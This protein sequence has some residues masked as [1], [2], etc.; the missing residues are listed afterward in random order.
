M[1][2]ASELRAMTFGVDEGVGTITLNRPDALNALNLELKAELAATIAEIRARP[3][4]RAVVVTGAGRAFCAGGDIDEMDPGRTP[5]AART[6]LLKL[7]EEVFIPLAR[8]EKPVIAA[9]NGHAHGA[10]CSLALAADMI[11]A[12]E[13]AVFSLAFA[14]LG[15]VPDSCSLY[16]LPRRLPINRAKEL[17]FSA[18]RFDAAEGERL[19]LV[20]RVL[21]DEE[22]MPVALEEAARLAS[23][24]TTAL[25]LAKRLLDQSSQ[26]TI[27][28]M[29]QF[30]AYA[31]AIATGTEDHREGVAAFHE[32]RPP[33]FTGR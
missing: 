10:G 18:R 25:G 3:D 20:N 1:A 12:A 32:K 8:L 6:R 4:V 29:A 13:S 28:D 11:Y 9:V 19:G 24:A 30:E 31:Q 21:P 17:V 23:G 14:R 26:L 22:L 2:A 16:F 27:D 15:L 33:S 5:P 7:L